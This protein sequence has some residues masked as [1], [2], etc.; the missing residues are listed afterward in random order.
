MPITAPSP[1]ETLY[2]PQHE[3]DSARLGEMARES[4]AGSIES[5][6]PDD[7]FVIN[8]DE[9]NLLVS[10]GTEEAGELP[11]G[12]YLMDETVKEKLGQKGIGF[13]SI[14]RAVI[15]GF[16][17]SMADP[18]LSDKLKVGRHQS[19]HDVFFC[20]VDLEGSALNGNEQAGHILVAIKPH[21]ENP[22]KLNK[23][24]LEIGNLAILQEL[25][26]PGVYT[27]IGLVQKDGIRFVMT[28][29]K[30]GVRTLD[31]HNWLKSAGQLPSSDSEREVV[32]ERDTALIRR[33]F[34][35]L[36][37]LHAQG[38]F[39]GDAQKKNIGWANILTAKKDAE[40]E[41]VY[42]RVEKIE[43]LPGIKLTILDVEN[44]KV[45]HREDG[46]DFGPEYY[47]QV[48][49]L[50]VKDVVMFFESLSKNIRFPVPGVVGNSRK[51]LLSPDEK[52]RLISEFVEENYINAYTDAFNNQRAKLLGEGED[53]HSLGKKMHDNIVNGLDPYTIP[54]GYNKRRRVISGL[55]GHQVSHQPALRS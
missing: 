7:I 4:F 10:M 29:L 48:S 50:G 45:F 17:A 42:P 8:P 55:N 3:V 39:H 11:D 44:S 21:F 2:P 35:L 15:S 16:Q 26:M 13:D 33:V 19:K 12:I 40:I 31:D 43:D 51:E 9:Y 37:T 18:D 1:H 6:G 52:K 34:G 22:E 20:S 46:K 5:M 49:G 32:R 53:D 47:S 36:G 24:Y 28:E 14:N 23:P 30:P 54:K 25:E 41:N 27:P 38:I